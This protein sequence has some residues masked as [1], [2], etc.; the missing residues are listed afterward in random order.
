[1]S[2]CTS[3]IIGIRAGGVFSSN[4][5]RE[6]IISSIDTLIPKLEGDGI[7]IP[8]KTVRLCLSSQLDASKGSYFTIA[9]VFNYWSHDAADTF[10]KVLSDVFTTHIMHM[11]WN[12]ETGLVYNSLWRKGLPIYL[13]TPSVS[14]SYYTNTQNLIEKIL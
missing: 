7:S 1:M 8:F 9:G 12:E 6:E 13:H 11:S 10:C 14:G 4:Y 5:D 2:H 3:H